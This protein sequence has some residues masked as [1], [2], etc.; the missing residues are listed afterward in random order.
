[1]KAHLDPGNTFH[2]VL[3]GPMEDVRPNPK[4]SYVLDSQ[5]ITRCSL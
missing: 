4:G 2:S 1:M 5:V 3:E